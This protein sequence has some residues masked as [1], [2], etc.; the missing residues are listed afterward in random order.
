MIERVRGLYREQQFNVPSVM[1]VA[2]SQL[3]MHMTTPQLHCM[4]VKVCRLVAIPVCSHI[5]VKG[6]SS[7]QQNQNNKEKERIPRQ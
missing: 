5:R 3:F 2:S 6:H 1:D 7:K 4:F